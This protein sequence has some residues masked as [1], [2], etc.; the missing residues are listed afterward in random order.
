MFFIILTSFILL[1]NKFI[2]ADRTQDKV[3]IDVL[4]RKI[5]HLG[6]KED[7]EHISLEKNIADKINHYCSKYYQDYDSP[8]LTNDF[9]EE[10]HVQFNHD[11]S[12]FIDLI[13]TIPCFVHPLIARLKLALLTKI[14]YF[15][16][17]IYYKLYVGYYPEVDFNPF[18]R[19]ILHEI[20]NIKDSELE[21]FEKKF[22]QFP[23]P[24][25]ELLNL[26]KLLEQAVRLK[27]YFIT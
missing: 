13:K 18:S 24:S 23:K 20:N 14:D 22:P 7:T 1:Q 16:T 17:D 2:E 15:L 4:K 3:L 19:I 27:E 11:F 21:E 10:K 26:N 9:S 5:V 12:K 8:G 25:N 6:D